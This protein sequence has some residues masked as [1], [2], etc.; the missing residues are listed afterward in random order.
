VSD[1]GTA[2]T[3]NM[4]KEY[5]EQRK[6]QHCL[7]TTGVPRGNGQVERMHRIVVPMLSKLSIENPGLWYKHVGIVQQ[8]I[9]NI[10]PRSTKVTP[11]KILTGIDMRCTNDIELKD[12]VQQSL[13]DE[14]NEERDILRSEA[15]ENIRALQDENQRTFNKKRKIEKEYKVNDLVAIKRTQYG[16]GLKL[17]GK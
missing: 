3:A 14:L 12:L 7:I 9:N 17:K 2:F 13:L 8:A 16:V 11:F 1:R 4:F 6:I 10:E 15:R 5:C